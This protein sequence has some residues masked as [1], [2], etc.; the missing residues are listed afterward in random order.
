MEIVNVE[1]IR[2]IK[3]ADL[4]EFIENFAKSDERVCILDN[5]DVKTVKRF[6]YRKKYKIRVSKKD[7]KIVLTK[8]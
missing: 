2:K 4:K 3:K 1:E 8:W 6:I 7:D 5:A